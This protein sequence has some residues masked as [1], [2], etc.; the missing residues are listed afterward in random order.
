MTTAINRPETTQQKARIV[1]N[2]GLLILPR[3]GIIGRD[4]N[5]PALFTLHHDQIRVRLS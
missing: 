5:F 2:A 3:D 1:K 4:I